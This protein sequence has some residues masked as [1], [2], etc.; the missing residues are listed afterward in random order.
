MTQ[1]PRHPSTVRIMRYFSFAHLPEGPLRNTSAAF[2][3]LANL[4]LSTLP[5][6]PE[7]TAG[8]RKLLEAKD[9]CVRAALDVPAPTGYARGGRIE[10]TSTEDEA[11]RRETA[12]HADG[13]SILGGT[14]LPSKTADP[15]AIGR[16]TG[17]AAF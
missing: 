17:L 9:C 10:Q 16:A 6:G 7:L 8:L 11:A 4:M 5:D 2:S 12:A 15:D 1:S 3:D 13:V 14:I